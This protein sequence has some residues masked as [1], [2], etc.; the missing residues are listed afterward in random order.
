MQPRFPS[1]CFFMTV[2]LAH[3][4]LLPL[5]PRYAKHKR[6]PVELSDDIRWLER[7]EKEWVRYP[8][9]ARRNRLALKLLKKK[10]EKATKQL[11]FNEAVLKDEN[12]LSLAAY[13]S[14]K[15]MDVVMKVLCGNRT[16]GI[17]LTEV[18][19]LFKA[20][21][22]FYIEDVV[23]TFIFLLEHEGPLPGYMSLLRF[24]QH[25][26]ILIC[27]TGIFNNPYL[28]AKVVELLFY[29]CPQVRPAG[30]SFH[31]SV[32]QNPSAGEALFRSLVKFY[33]DVET[34]GSASEFYDK[35]NIRFHIQTIF[36]SMLDEPAC[37]AVMFDYCK[38]ADA[39][40]IRFVN[41]LINDTTYLLDESMEGLLRINS[42][43]GQMNDESRWWNLE[44]E[45]RQRLTVQHAHD[46]RIVR[47]SLQLARAT[48][49]MFGYMTKDVT[50]PF[51]TGELGDRLAAMLNYN[52]KQ[53][54]GPTSQRLRVK[55]PKRYTWEPRSL[56][57]ELT[58]IYLNLDCDKF[59][60][61]IVA[62]E[63]SY[64]PA[65]FRNVIECL[66]RHNI[67]SNS[68]VEQ[69]RLLAQK[70]HAVWKKRKQEDMVFS[71]VPT[72]FMVRLSV[73]KQVAIDQLSNADQLI[74]G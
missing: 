22:E 37:R 65:F 2:H 68:K 46:E 63:R 59:V 9:L 67:K 69:L 72:D 55:D 29:T 54:C 62:D 48:I 14:L 25:L 31:D 19:D 70:A 43:E 45:E 27:N 71:D 8:A 53:L 23:D 10:L 13:F 28:S 66:I 61:C 17:H 42:V 58:E 20:L 74:Y 41:M 4:A 21:P 16:D 15:Q 18:P 7:N 26:L 5:F 49:D 57:N 32:F 35:F 47:S 40:F 60:G 30:R 12:L 44:M 33:S 73:L 3:I 6:V 36:K 11:A 39:N 38:N 1:E 24:A 34:M 56:I 64:S 52:L 50:E 51:L